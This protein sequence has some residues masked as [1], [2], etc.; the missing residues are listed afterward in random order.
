MACAQGFSYWCWGPAGVASWAAGGGG[1][2]PGPHSLSPAHRGGGYRGGRAT[3]LPAALPSP[4]P[5]PGHFLPS[6]SRVAGGQIHH[7]GQRSG[8]IHTLSWAGGRSPSS[9]AGPSLMPPTASIP[10]RARG[11]RKSLKPRAGRA[12]E[13]SL[14][15]RPHPALTT[16]CS[17]VH[18]CGPDNVFSV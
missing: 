13:T 5:H 2:S 8:A 4:D 14:F 6:R 11:S 16:S 1:G 17:C 9:R 3:G 15:P 10:L 7:A 18:A 12:A